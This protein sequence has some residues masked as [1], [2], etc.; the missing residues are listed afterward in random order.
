LF[1]ELVASPIVITSSVG[2][3]AIG[4]SEHAL[5]MMLMLIGGSAAWS[6]AQ[7]ERRWVRQQH[8]ELNGLTC[9]IIGL[10]HL[11]RDLAEK[12][13]ACHMHVLGIRRSARSSEFVDE[14][15]P[16]DRLH[17]ML[18]R[19]DFVVVTAPL[20]RETRHLLGESE[21]RAMRPTSYY[22]CSSRGGIADEGALLRALHERW[23]AGAGLDAFADEPLP[24]D[25]PFWD[26]PNT[27]ITPHDGANTPRRRRV[28][29]E[30]FKANLRQYVDGGE[31]EGI[32]DKA[33]G[34]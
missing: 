14:Q 33:L 15:L 1:P 16:V 29:V 21:F 10:G 25:S 20:T 30:M 34:Y 27:I 28:S 8:G 12:A 22:I 5:R 11:G 6:Q 18:V 9:G 23:I 32:L 26:A 17:E 3:G 4:M 2:S 13:K 31:L 7:A 24:P 19:S